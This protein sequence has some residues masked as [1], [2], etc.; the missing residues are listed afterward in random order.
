MRQRPTSAVFDISSGGAAT[1]PAHDPS[2]QETANE[3]NET[4][5]KADWAELALI[6]AA[7][8]TTR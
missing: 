5:K 2:K 8:D 7:T 1:S 6:P 3:Y 4:T